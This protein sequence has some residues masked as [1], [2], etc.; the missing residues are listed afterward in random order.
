MDVLDILTLRKRV[1]VS[2]AGDYMCTRNRK[3]VINSRELM[4]KFG[5]KAKVEFK[6][7][8]TIGKKLNCIHE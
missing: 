8:R 2:L 6:Y 3:S 4:T 1:Y 5:R 7:L